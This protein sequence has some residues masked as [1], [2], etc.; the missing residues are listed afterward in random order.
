MPPYFFVSYARQDVKEAAAY[1]D[2]FLQDLEH[3]VSVLT[4]EPLEGLSFRDTDDIDVGK[5]WP[6]ELVTALQT[7]RAF[8]P[9]YSMRYFQSPYCGKE[10]QAFQERWGKHVNAPGPTIPPLVLP[11]IWAPVEWNELSLPAE[12]LHHQYDH[13]E[14][15]PEY[16]AEGLRTLMRLY[17][18]QYDVFVTR[19]ARRL[20]AAVKHHPLPAAPERPNFHAL[21][22]A[23]H[24]RPDGDA[25][26]S[27]VETPGTR[28]GGPFHVQF[29]V[30]AGRADEMESVRKSVAAYGDI[31]EHWQP[32]C[33]ITR[34]E[35]GLLVGKIAFN[36]G[37]MGV[38]FLEPGQSLAGQFEKARRDRTIL[39]LLVDPW[40]LLLPSYA[41]NATEFD[42]EQIWHATVLIPWNDNDE[43]TKQRA[44]ELRNL[45]DQVF[46][47]KAMEHSLKS[48]PPL[49][50]CGYVNSKA[51]LSVQLRGVLRR[52]S[53]GII[54]RTSRPRV[55]VGSRPKPMPQLSGPGR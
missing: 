46:E 19:Y 54:T 13:P 20:V 27:S 25:R 22:S 45:I 12:I 31:R 14:L 3:E 39:V 36:A 26:A 28:R 48:G 35:I 2:R 24:L 50:F 5:P 51:Q 53:Q 29:I 8:L 52:I 23:F 49:S 21:S 37:F 11:V 42:Q 43:E 9:L 15:G 6:D 7:S 34:E 33:P 10:W 1:F 55:A 30:L 40:S 41:Q 16:A 44:S 38:G 18:S 47:N 4:G 32:F 17:H